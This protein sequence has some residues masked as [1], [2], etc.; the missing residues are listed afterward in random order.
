MIINIILSDKNAFRTPSQ[1]TVWS[2]LR[3]RA[4]S[5]RGVCI[6]HRGHRSTRLIDHTYRHAQK[7]CAVINKLTRTIYNI[8]I[9]EHGKGRT[10]KKQL[11]CS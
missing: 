8:I 10:K 11:Y 6:L 3:T 1:A 9:M 2:D 5:N 4:V 7:G